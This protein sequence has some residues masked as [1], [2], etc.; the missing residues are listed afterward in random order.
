MKIIGTGIDVVEI[1]QIKALL[2]SPSR[3]FEA[4]CFTEAELTEVRVGNKL[5]LV[6]ERFAAKESVL[7]ALGTG[8]AQGIAWTDVEILRGDSAV[9]RVLLDG[10]AA[11]IAVSLGITDWTLGITRCKS[12]A[13]AS[14]IA[15]Q[16]E[17][18]IFESS[19]A[20]SADLPVGLSS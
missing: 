3:H 10:K 12:Y 11:Q 7:K 9:P 4:S 17:T 8:W 18:K 13:I 16:C 2:Q 6:A 19:H 5:P 15:W 1:V 14:A 20:F